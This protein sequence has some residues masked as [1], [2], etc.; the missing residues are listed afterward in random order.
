MRAW[1]RQDWHQTTGLEFFR[2]CSFSY[3][4]PFL[5]TLGQ[6][7]PYQGKQYIRKREVGEERE[8]KREKGFRPM[9]CGAEAG[10]VRLGGTNSCRK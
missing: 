4:L 3:C 8:R 5:Y 1:K 9:F 10:Q 6:V 7:R 2:C